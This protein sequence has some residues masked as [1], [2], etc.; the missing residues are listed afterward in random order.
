METLLA[1]SIKFNREI[2]P[3]GPFCIA[4]SKDIDEPNLTMPLMDRLLAVLSNLNTE[5]KPPNLAKLRNEQQ[6]P[7]SKKSNTDV[8]PRN[9]LEHIILS[10]LPHVVKPLID[11]ELPQTPKTMEENLPP[12]RA[13]NPRSERLLPTAVLPTTDRSNMDPTAIIPIA[14]NAEPI[15]TKLLT[16][17]A[18][19]KFKQL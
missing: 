3:P 17:I 2:A 6:L 12:T 18:E 8:S 9:A 16:D 1:I 19:P 15:L 7:N 5:T 11:T 10:L 4:P 14:E 13:E